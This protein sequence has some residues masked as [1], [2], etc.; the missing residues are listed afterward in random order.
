VLNNTKTQ[1]RVAHFT[2]TV[3]HCHCQW[4]SLPVTL[5][6]HEITQKMVGHPCSMRPD[7]QTAMA[8]G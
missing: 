3:S 7:E 4:Q 6:K 5:C 2:V 8:H 1:S